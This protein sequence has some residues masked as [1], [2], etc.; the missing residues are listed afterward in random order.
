MNLKDLK[1]EIDKLA[2]HMDI[3]SY[4]DGDNSS[5]GWHIDEVHGIWRFYSIEDY[6][7]YGN[8]KIFY[9][10]DELCKY[11]LQRNKQNNEF[12]LREKY[13]NK[14]KEKKKIKT[15]PVFYFLFN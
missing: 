13:E 1:D 5:M 9:S 11:V 2:F 7:K 6:G 10:E 3:V 8:E 14:I 12:Y 15:P 4:N